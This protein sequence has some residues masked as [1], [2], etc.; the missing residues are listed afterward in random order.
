MLQEYLT[1]VQQNYVQEW[2]LRMVMFFGISSVL[3]FS[4]TRFFKSRF[5]SRKIQ[6]KEYKRDKI[7][8]DVLWSL[9]NRTLLSLV[10]V[11]IAFFVFKDYSLIYTDINQYGW[12][13]FLFSI[14]L[15]LFIHDTYFYFV[16]RL[17]H[18]K[19]LMRHVHRLHHNSTD[20]TPYTGYAFH[21]WETILE[22]AF[23]PL[24]VFVLP[25]HPIT[26]LGW[27]LSILLFTMYAHLGYE[28][29]PKFWVTNPITKYFNTPT[30]HNMHHAKF[31][32]NY[33]LYFNFWDRLFKTQHP[34]YEAVF[35]ETVNRIVPDGQ[36]SAKPETVTGW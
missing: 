34:E 19:L 30:H 2:I 4:F 5:A 3:Y 36:M 32:C 33:G 26:F 8:H 14:P 29:M 22:F 18:H 7:Q 1:Y 12:A 10:T 11:T 16:H 17:M 25:L 35:A 21:P 27:Q 31:L 9:F 23:L 15:V 6:Q 13:Y 20:P 24:I 28:V